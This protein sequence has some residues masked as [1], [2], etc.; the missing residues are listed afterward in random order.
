MAE[1]KS[2]LNIMCKQKSEAND[3]CYLYVIQPK[4]DYE[5]LNEDEDNWQGKIYH[6]QNFNKQKFAEINTQV[7]NLANKQSQSNK[8]IKVKMD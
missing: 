7:K 8:E 1:M 3:K 4:H 2:I 5:D 6:Q